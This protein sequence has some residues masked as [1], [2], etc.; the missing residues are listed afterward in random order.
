MTKKQEFLDKVEAD[1]LCGEDLFLLLEI[2]KEFSET[3]ED[4]IELLEDLKEDEENIIMNFLV[5]DR[6]AYLSIIEGIVT[7]K[8]DELA[9]NPTFTII[10]EE[11]TALKILKG[12]LPL[13]QAYKDGK[14]KTEGQLVKVASLSIMMNIVGD[15][16]GV[17]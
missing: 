14:I 7:T 3:N 6:R 13:F 8:R 5:D 9:N 11:A 2:I 1:N 16:I 17:L 10:M 4:I 15:E 12:Q